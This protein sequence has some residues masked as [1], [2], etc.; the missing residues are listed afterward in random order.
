MNVYVLATKA[1]EKILCEIASH[2]SKNTDEVT[3]MNDTGYDYSDPVHLRHIEYIF[4][5]N[6]YQLVFTG[7][8]VA[9]YPYDYGFS[10][11]E[12][13]IKVDALMSIIKVKDEVKDK[14]EQEHSEV[15]IPQK[16][17]IL[18]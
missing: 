14:F 4:V 7:Q 2:L 8:G 17:L 11:A 1:G 13:A 12:Y 9:Q 18:N 3:T 10:E 6:T 5:R 15:Y 16:K